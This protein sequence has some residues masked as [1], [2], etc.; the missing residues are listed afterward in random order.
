MKSAGIPTDV[1]VGTTVKHRRMVKIRYTGNF[2]EAIVVHYI[3]TYV[4]PVGDA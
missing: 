2:D 1:L 3:S 4:C